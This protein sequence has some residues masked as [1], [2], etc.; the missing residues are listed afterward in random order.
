MS[1]IIID[2]TA[3]SVARVNKGHVRVLGKGARSK[4]MLES[5]HIVVPRFRGSLTSTSAT[6]LGKRLGAAQRVHT[7]GGPTRVRQRHQ[8]MAIG[9][10]NVFSITGKEQEL[11]GEAKRYR[12][13]IVGVSST[14]RRGSGTVDL[15]GG[16][17]LFYSGVDPDMTAQAGV[18]ILTSPR[19]ADCVIDWNP[20]GGRVCLLRLRLKERTLALLMVY[21]PN[22]EAEYQPFLDEVDAAL[23]R[24]AN[25]D[26]IILM[27]DFN[28]HV[29]TDSLTWKGVIGRNGDSDLNTNGR[30]LLDLCC[31]NGLSIMNTFFQH[32]DVHKYTWYRGALGQRSLIDFFIVSADLFSHVL[33][34]RVKRG[35]ELSTD[36]HLAV[37]N[38]RLSENIATRKSGRPSQAYR[39]KWE[40]LEDEKV[41]KIFADDI[42]SRFNE[43][44]QETAG[45]ETEWELFKTA[46]TAS[47]LSC[48]GR[49]R[50][51]VATGSEKRTPWWNEEVQEAVRAKK[52][53]YLAWLSNKSPDLRNRYTEARKTS[54]RI[55]R[56]A[57]AES[58]EKFGER[59]ELN[60]STANKVFWQTI[61]RL[62]GRKSSSAR[63]I[64][65]SEG[66]LLTNERDI[67]KR[68]G[69]YFKD[70][71]NPV[72][73][74]STEAHEV[75]LGAESSHGGI[76]EAEVS[77]AI[78]LLKSGKAAGDDEIRPE[79][80][81]A[82]NRDGVLWLTRVCQVAWVSGQAPKQ[83]QSGVVIPIFK[84]GDQRDCNNY[85][86]I[87]LLSLPGKT[88]AKCLEK[89]CRAIVE[90]NLADHQCGFRPGRS[91]TDQIFALRLI[92][93]K[94]W[95]YA[96]DIF[97]CFVD[98]EKAYDRVPRQ[99]LWGV[100]QEYGI[101]GQLL[102]AVKSLYYCSE[103]CVRVNG[104]KS[105]PFTVGVGLRQGCVLSPLLFI[106]FMD[107]IDRHSRG[108]ECVTIGDCSV[109]RLLFADDLV[110][111]SSSKDDLQRALDR[112]AA[113]CEV[114]GM[115]I[116]VAKTEALLLSRQPAQCILH[117]SGV[118]L[119]Q[120]EKFKYLG[121]AFASDGRQDVELDTR[122][123]AASAVR[124]ELWRSVV[125]KRELRMKPKL[126][127]F[128]SVYVP[129][130]TYGHESWV[131]TERV[132]SRVQAA[133]MRFLRGVEGVTL[134]DRVRSTTIRESLQIEPLL[135]WIERSQLR[136]YGHLIR[137]P[138]ERIPRQLLFAKPN[139]RRPVGRPR[140][141][142]LD[143]IEN[144]GSSRLVLP[145]QQL[146]L[147]A[148]D[149]TQWKSALER[150]P[151][152]P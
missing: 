33:D 89:R 55:V 103:M 102:A 23:Q 97:A 99:K 41:R 91:T 29:G 46:V 10:W 115:R 114:A 43:L 4:N 111:L 39:I 60:Y 90:E 147:V 81:K 123:A 16:W 141:R 44:P 144:L 32:R 106:I 77:S 2:H 7:L 117:V 31:S 98:L 54:A 134:L 14:K 8:T 143:Y 94:C 1:S 136:W 138:Q 140:T 101:N 72:T 74:T 47:A 80:L 118:P 3:S 15:D 132:R 151:P 145:S 126:S 21:A 12:L 61:R 17:K 109:D 92:V 110:L 50:L 20:L 11:V 70:L 128:K 84:K 152:R 142:W 62:R 86:G 108:A 149:R 96:K 105:N 51:G 19:L 25:M 34:V 26:S 85:R 75:H 129:I 95:E 56:E 6:C 82:L 57:K 121:V 13:D 112:F 64:K 146:R 125:M 5:P 58:W 18:G 52:A 63:T 113:M 131:M 107:W 49:K 73:V 150:L 79:M 68:W 38:L 120:V 135:L 40:A 119:K 78:K 137:M 36:H 48:C 9:N 69:E 148:E 59:L 127:V 100:L 124:R 71:L 30:R 28:A 133:E 66:T 37:C 35:A 83:W 88:Y 65:S 53:A 76:S 116:S 45:I 104:N 22:A 93:E 87:S 42:T 24:V 67:L 122:I 139:G 130:L 27:G